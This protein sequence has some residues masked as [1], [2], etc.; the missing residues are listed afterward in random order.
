MFSILLWSSDNFSS[1]STLNTSWRKAYVSSNYPTHLWF[2]Y[3][4]PFLNVGE[5]RFFNYEHSD[6]S[7]HGSNCLSMKLEKEYWTDICA[8]EEIATKLFSKPETT[9]IL[10]WRFLFAY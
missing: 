8:H 4:L 10:A 5:N 2:A 1:S 9:H 6:M 3:Q 7:D